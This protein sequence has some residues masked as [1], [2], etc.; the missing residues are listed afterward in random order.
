M[1]SFKLICF[2][3]DGTLVRDYNRHSY[4]G[5]IHRELLND[6][7]GKKNK[8]RLDKFMRGKFSYKEWVDM[9]LSMF[10]EAGIKKEDFVRV[11]MLHT[12]FPGVHETIQ[13][14]KERGLKLGIISGSLNILISTLFPENPFDDIFVNEVFFDEEGFISSWTDTVY[15]QGSKHLALK[16]ICEREGIPLEQTIFVGDE[17][18]D[19]DI[20]KE[21]GLGI[22]FNAKK[23]SVKDAAD[24]VIEGD[25]LLE[26]LEYL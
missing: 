4:W 11:A 3:L 13:Q 18:N 25:N 19:I 7:D 10:K 8:E 5:T 12:L 17:E 26:I 21:A 20:L 14:L 16:H 1:G 15:D 24:R 22:A 6:K 9:D 23:Q 2:D